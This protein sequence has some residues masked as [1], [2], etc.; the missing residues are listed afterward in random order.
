VKRL[1]LGELRS[2]HEL[3]GAART[4]KKMGFGPIELYSPFP[5]ESAE[6]EELL[7][8]PR[9]WLPVLT[10]VAGL[11][12]AICAYLIQ[13][14]CNVISW[15]LVVGGHPVHAP[16][17]YVPICFETGVL[18]AAGTAFFGSIWG[19]G[20]PRLNH[21]VFDA[22]GFRSVTQDGF[23]VGVETESDFEHANVRAALVELGVAQLTEVRS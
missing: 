22:E 21:P 13:W 11:S 20:L 12:G 10:L 2:E 7:H 19:S 9:S 14:Y 23:W 5:L 8:I 3:L 18:C 6:V 17:A 4:L 1:W 16:P 15:P